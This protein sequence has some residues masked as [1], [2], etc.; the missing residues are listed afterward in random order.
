[1]AQNAYMDAALTAFLA[2]RR[3]FD[4][5]AREL[6][7]ACQATADLDQLAQR[8]QRFADDRYLPFEMAETL[9]HEVGRQVSARADGAQPEGKARSSADQTVDTAI[10]S[11]L[12]DRF[13]PLRS[14]R[15][16][17]PSD[18]PDELDANLSAFRSLRFRKDAKA[19][20]AGQR[21]SIALPT[22]PAPETLVGLM[23][24][25]RFVLDSELG[26]GGMG[27]VFRAVDR[28]RL[29]AGAPD[30]Y[31]AIKLLNEEFSSHP[32]ALRTMEAEARRTQQLT[33][34]T[35]LHVHDFDRDGRHAFIVMELLNGAALDAVIYEQ[36]RFPGTALAR[37]AILQMCAGIAFAHGRGVIHADLK[38][39]NLFLCKD[40][41]L[42]ILDFGISSAAQSLDFDAAALGALTPAYASPERLRSE[43]LTPSDDVYALGCIVHLLLT[44]RHPFDRKSGQEAQNEGLVPPPLPMLVRREERAVRRA[45]NF[46][47][48]ERQA[49][50]GV[51]LA[52]YTG[53]A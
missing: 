38:L 31:V 40:G 30:P 39:A 9:L 11:A 15:R 14:G 4:Q 12:V 50:A 18:K 24:R 26:R 21:R 3:T 47:G 13:K 42:K 8:L 28:R 44:G 16:S 43:P 46:S 22:G 48:P 20:I 45:L 32:D 49:D 19:A 35:I 23:L 36:P 6:A 41:R 17:A 34:P 53:E 51:F 52:E 25:D 33:H 10:I 2:G 37:D 5:L 7:G 1:M 29:E 27:V